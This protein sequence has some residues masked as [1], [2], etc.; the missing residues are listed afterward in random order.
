MSEKDFLRQLWNRI[1][2][3]LSG[4]VLTGAL[5]LIGFYYSTTFRLEQFDAE[6]KEKA[7]I[8]QVEYF[9]ESAMKAIDTEKT[10]RQQEMTHIKELLKDI[11]EKL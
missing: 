5:T 8:T 6:I 9:R 2:I 7:S 11:K 10:F 3:L 4:V 1:I